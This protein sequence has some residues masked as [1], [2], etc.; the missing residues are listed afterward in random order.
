MGVEGR[1]EKEGEKVEQ[2]NQHEDKGVKRGRRRQK[3]KRKCALA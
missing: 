2:G 3:R 1:E